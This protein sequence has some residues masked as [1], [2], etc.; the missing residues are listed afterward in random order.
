MFTGIVEQLVTVERVGAGAPHRIWLGYRGPSI[1]VGDSIALNGVCLTAVED[2][3]GVVQVDV[4]TETLERTNLKSLKAGDQ[5]NLER[6]MAADG[7][8]DGHIVQGHV[9]GVGTLAA[10]TERDDGRRLTVSIPKG[11][12]RFI[13][14]KGSIAVDGVSLT[15]ASLQGEDCE[16]A[17]IPHTALVTT[18]GLRQVGDSVN[19]EVDVI[20]KYVQRMLSDQP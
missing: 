4:V 2:D 8:F 13:V 10:I 17:I 7:R 20:A 5:V 9:D 12:E 16:I 15:I 19:L 18:L 1:G 3:E 14:E 6:A 11:L